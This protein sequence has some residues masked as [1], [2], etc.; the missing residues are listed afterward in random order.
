MCITETLGLMPQTRWT[1]TYT[2]ER[3]FGMLEK[4]GKENQLTYEGNF[5]SFYNNKYVA[6]HDKTCINEI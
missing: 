6:R 1:D 2:E 4:R 3:E 5:I